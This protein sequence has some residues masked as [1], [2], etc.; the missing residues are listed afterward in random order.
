MFNVQRS[1]FISRLWDLTKSKSVVLTG[2]PGVGKTWTIGQILRKCKQ[3]N[4]KVLS[5]AA[6]DFDVS[7]VDEL[8]QSIGFKT[9]LFSVLASFGPESLLVIDGLDALRGEAS[10]KAFRD[11]MESVSAQVPTCTILATVRTFDLQQSPELQRLFFDFRNA[12]G[13]ESVTTPPFSDDD[14]NV[15]AQQV[16]SLQSV[17]TGTAQ[18]EIRELLR[19]PFNLRLAVDL[20]EAGTGIDEFSTIHSQVQLLQRYWFMRVESA[21]DAP[22][23]KGL[24]R[25]IVRGMVDRKA[26]SI[27]E[28]AA[29]SAGY[30]ASLR[31]LRSAEVLRESVTDRISFSHNILFDYAVARLLLDEEE[32]FS[33]LNSDSSRIIFFRPSVLHFFHHLWWND[34]NVFWNL[35]FRFL[36][37]D[38]LPE[39]AKVIPAIVVAEASRSLSDLE[40][41]LA[42]QA[43]RKLAVPIILRAV[44]A[45]GILETRQR[46]LW[47]DFLEKL[48]SEIELEF[49]NEF[50]SVMGIV[51][52]QRRNVENIQIGSISRRLL[53]WMWNSADALPKYQGTQLT[54]IAAGRVMPIV[55]Q[56]YATDRAA[57]HQIVESVLNRLGSPS[58]SSHD[59]FWLAHEIQHII[60]NDSELAVRVYE[61]MF[62][63]FE[64]SDETTVM[65]GSPVFTL[66]STRKQDFETAL[67]GLQQA[68]PYFLKS[69]PIH[70]ALAAVKA[71]NAEVSRREISEN[72]P[73]KVPKH[74]TFRFLNVSA[75]YVSDF[76][77]IWD[78][79]ARD[80][81]SLQLLNAV[82]QQAG[83]MTPSAL[84][85]IVKVIAQHARVAVCWKR[86]LEAASH[87]IKDFFPHVSPLLT[88]PRFLA[89]PEIAVVAGNVLKAAY[90]ES[91]PNKGQKE[92]IEDAIQRI[93]RSRYIKR[94]EKPES[95]QNR[96]LLCIG[97][98]QLLSPVLR[99]RA[100]Q[101]SKEKPQFANEPYVR[102]QGGAMSYS[103]EDWLRDEGADTTKK[104]NVEILEA[105]KPL[106]GF[107]HKF[108][109]G[110]PSVEDCL[111]IEPLLTRLNEL[112]Q[113]GKDDVDP[114]I[115]EHARGV[116]YAAAESAVKNPDL[117]KQHPLTQLCK[118]LL[119]Q[120]AAD[121][122]PKFDPKYHSKFDMPSWGSPI[123]RIEAAQGVSHYLWNYGPDDEIVN[124]IAK[125]SQ[126]PV[127]AVRY[128]IAAGLPGFY[129]HHA[130]QRF[131]DIATE[132]ID[133]ET[134]PGVMLGLVG[135]LGRVAGPDPEHVVEL[136]VRAVKRGLPATDR[137]E[138]TRALVQI[139]TGLYAVRNHLGAGEQLARFEAEPVRYASEVANEIFTASHYLI[140]NNADDAVRSRARELF[141]R[142]LSSC[143]E[144]LQKAIDLP[145][146]EDKAKTIKALMSHVDEV[147]TRIYFSLDLKPELR[148]PEKALVEE[149]R[150]QLYLELKPL[151]AALATGSGGVA[152]HY[153]VPRTAHYLLET[154]NGVLQY[155]PGDVIKFAAQTC[156]AASALNYQFDAMA[157]SEVVKLV[158]HS[159]ADHKDALKDPSIATA[160]GE[161]LDLFVRAGWPDALRLTFKLDQ[162]MR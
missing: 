115:S 104:E 12:R 124:A 9:D 73:S 92:K 161:I 53:A 4:R 14:L 119:L 90:S 143:Y 31:A 138:V 27:R 7:S 146:S 66:T 29:Y 56:L 157:I 70:A 98:D 40:P 78:H 111:G 125:L 133:T 113:K 103:T 84:R 22:D 145:D 122:S 64:Q 30:A 149:H 100:E 62:S 88:I 91:L 54:G 134:T 50:V 68:F 71:T 77:E 86:L 3:E 99:E 34:R 74:F 96:L 38:D 36:K 154:L 17:L 162:A 58:S 107:E 81:L 112:L 95:I 80:H 23:R 141:S 25:Q 37:T 89:A 156:K 16:P 135:T 142:V 120:G 159:L 130:E 123:P 128:Q 45:L 97:P 114:Q 85:E 21:P 158:E 5:L 108:L 6:E 148:T 127:P 121:P 105:I 41:V 150:R 35:S 151:I 51:N 131:W 94:Y 8:Q 2:S 79:G 87:S 13:F 117:G 153:L 28:E 83:E 116:L 132:M 52:Q 67:Y 49:I 55:M 39:R 59:A 48:S 57:S 82:L 118:M 129:K 46:S 136:L 32:I 160:L 65:G 33:F 140:P 19:T 155:D 152:R 75:T 61:Q 42:N 93:P 26:L 106:T 139:L 43:T 18:T 44:Q 20:L 144:N 137:T 60:D 101:L 109:N 1:D 10:Q 76:S 126:D 47:L 102:M 15:A 69:S 11:L 72:E 110:V 147:A 63:Y 24:L